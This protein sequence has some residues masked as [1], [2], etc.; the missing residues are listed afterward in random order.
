MK[1]DIYNALGVHGWELASEL[2][3]IGGNS[4]DIIDRVQGMYENG[5]MTDIFTGAQMSVQECAEECVK[6][7]RGELVRVWVGRMSRE[8]V[9]ALMTAFSGLRFAEIT[10]SDGVELF[11]GELSAKWNDAHPGEDPVFAVSADEQP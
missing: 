10:L 1:H 6:S 9:S 2:D 5:Q 4:Q 11:P 3:H 7:L 8:T